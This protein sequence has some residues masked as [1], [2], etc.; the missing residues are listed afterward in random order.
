MYTVEEIVSMTSLA[1][2]GAGILVWCC[3]M[4]WDQNALGKVIKKWI[5]K[6]DDIETNHTKLSSKTEVMEAK[7]D[8]MCSVVLEDVKAKRKDLWEHHSPLK[9]T[10]EAVA[11][12]PEDIMEALKECNCNGDRNC[13]LKALYVSDK[14]SMERLTSVAKEKGMTL[15]ELTALITDI[16]VDHE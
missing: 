4:Q 1:A 13:M 16:E 12:I 8:F 9:P 7:Y 6:A 14:I 2:F 15:L 11:L 10:P 5:K 3:K